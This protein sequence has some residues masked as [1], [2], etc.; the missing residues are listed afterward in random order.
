MTEALFK[1]LSKQLTDESCEVPPDGWRT[2]AS[3]SGRR[4]QDQFILIER[5]ATVRNLLQNVNFFE[6]SIDTIIAREYS[7]ILTFGCAF[8]DKI[9]RDD[10]G[11]QLVAHHLALHLP[12]LS[13]KS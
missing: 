9:R 7:G 6:K 8:I 2:P 11:L 13:H 1:P 12:G 4:C 10:L 3:Y 5:G